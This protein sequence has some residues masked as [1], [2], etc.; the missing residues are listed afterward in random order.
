MNYHN[1]EIINYILNTYRLIRSASVTFTV[2]AGGRFNVRLLTD[3]VDNRLKALND[4]IDCCDLRSFIIENHGRYPE[5]IDIFGIQTSTQYMLSSCSPLWKL[6]LCPE[7]ISLRFNEGKLFKGVFR[8]SRDDRCRGC[9]FI[10]DRDKIK[11][12]VEITGSD[13]D[14]YLIYL[15]S[16]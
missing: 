8:R 16:F 13:V 3:D 15:N 4:T 7:E 9:V 5:L 6:H 11:K 10:N 2:F 1:Y 12:V 14:Y